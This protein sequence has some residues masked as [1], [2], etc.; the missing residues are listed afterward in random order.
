VKIFLKVGAISKARI[1]TGEIWPTKANPSLSSSDED[2]V[3]A[4]LLWLDGVEEHYWNKFGRFVCLHG[5]HQESLLGPPAS[6]C[7]IR[8]SNVDTIE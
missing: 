2:L 3:L 6:H 1:P 8:F 4:K 5:T 7:C